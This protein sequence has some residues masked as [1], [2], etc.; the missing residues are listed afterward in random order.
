MPELIVGLSLTVPQARQ[1][2]AETLGQLGPFAKGAVEALQRTAQDKDPA[3][4][5]AAEKALAKIQG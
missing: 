2:A 5:A 1:N 4:R 3:V